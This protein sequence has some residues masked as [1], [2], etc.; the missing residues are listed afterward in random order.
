VSSEIAAIIER[1][2]KNNFTTDDDV[3]RA[4]NILLQ[5]QLTVDEIKKLEDLYKGVRY[6]YVEKIT[7][8]ALGDEKLKKT[9]E[10]RRLMQEYE[11]KQ[12]EI[13]QNKFT[14]PP[15]PS[16]S[17]TAA[18]SKMPTIDISSTPP[19]SLAPSPTTVSSTPAPAPTPTPAPTPSTPT[20]PL[21]SGPSATATAPS[22]V[23]PPVPTPTP[24]PQ[25][26]PQ[27]QQ[28]TGLFGWFNRGVSWFNT[29]FIAPV[30]N[31][32]SGLWNRFT[33]WLF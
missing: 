4:M 25:P 14:T 27:P 7:P 29:S 33:S 31:L 13:N 12:S 10:I 2:A 9:F 24:T 11:R 28:P 21:T 1:N 8:G 15:P 23:T 5:E 16:S 26:Q 3:E 30:G 17:T 6:L 32:L 22:P 20:P 19:S 18:S